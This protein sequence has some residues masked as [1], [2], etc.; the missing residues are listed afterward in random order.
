MK[1]YVILVFII[2]LSLP[3][4]PGF[5][6]DECKPK[7]TLIDLSVEAAKPALNDLGR[8]TIYVEASGANPA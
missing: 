5:S 7:G 1:R 6:A 4:S 2:V 8:A 3:A